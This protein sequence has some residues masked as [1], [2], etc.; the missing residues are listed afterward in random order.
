[1][2]PSVS[3]LELAMPSMHANYNN[4]QD[5]AEWLHGPGRSILRFGPLLRIKRGLTSGNG[6]G[7]KKEATDES[8]D[9]SLYPEQVTSGLIKLSNAV[10]PS[11]QEEDLAILKNSSG[12]KDVEDDN[13]EMEVDLSRLDETTLVELYHGVEDQTDLWMAAQHKSKRKRANKNDP[14]CMG[15]GHSKRKPGLFGKVHADRDDD[16]KIGENDEID[17]VGI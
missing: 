3:P 14:A 13:D 1:M 2:A 12:Q 15:G 6:D 7:D 4:Y 17:I 8:D 5:L 16:M 10:I 9:G 11:E